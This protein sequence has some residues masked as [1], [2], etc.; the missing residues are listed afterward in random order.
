MPDIV[1]PSDIKKQLLIKVAN[2]DSADALFLNSIIATFCDPSQNISAECLRNGLAYI[3][4]GKS[5]KMQLI[6]RHDQLFQGN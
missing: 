5:G 4:Y 1:T 3:A 2:L 6:H